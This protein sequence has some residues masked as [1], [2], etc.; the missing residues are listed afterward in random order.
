MKRKISLLSL[1]V[2]TAVLTGCNESQNE[3]NKT[4]SVEETI[5][6]IEETT[7]Y[8]SLSEPLADIPREDIKSVSIERH[9]S[10]I[11]G[12]LND[13]QTDELWKIM[14]GYTVYQKDNSYG[15]YDGG[16][17]ILYITKQMERNLQLWSSEIF[18]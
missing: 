17:N 4:V 8:P 7:G 16:G 1:L 3:E 18:L 12:V 5:E 15:E 13:E 10:N 2:M 14:S 6:I 11:T 9:P